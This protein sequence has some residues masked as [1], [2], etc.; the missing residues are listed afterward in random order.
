LRSVKSGASRL[1]ERYGI[2]WIAYFDDDWSGNEVS[3]KDIVSVMDTAVSLCAA[4][5]NA[6]VKLRWQHDF[7]SKKSGNGYNELQ[8]GADEKS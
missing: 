3:C 4:L 5:N 6:S 1:N 7:R 8:L 2:V